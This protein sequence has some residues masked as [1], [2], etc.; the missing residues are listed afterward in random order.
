MLADMAGPALCLVNGIAIRAVDI[1]A[2]LL[3]FFS[4]HAPKLLVSVLINLPYY[5]HFGSCLAAV[6]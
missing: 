5:P 2:N 6:R 4:Y 3:L 1:G